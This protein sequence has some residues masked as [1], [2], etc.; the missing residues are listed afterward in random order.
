MLL[1][2]KLKSTQRT[3]WVRRGVKHPESIADHMYRMAALSMIVEPHTGLSKDKCI[4]LAL[5]H[6]MAESITGD[7]TPHDGVSKEEKHRREAVSMRHIEGL[8][9][10]DAGLEIYNLWLEYET[11]SSAEAQFV[12]DVDKFDMILQA[13]EYETEE[14]RPKELE[15]FFQSTEGKFQTSIVR[16]WVDE[17]NDLRRKNSAICVGLEGLLCVVDQSDSTTC[18]SRGVEDDVSR[19]YSTEFA[20]DKLE[21]N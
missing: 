6:D 1:M 8:V 9:G 10:G 11:Q 3:G 18:N 14:G 4:K 2:G 17:L 7:L 19:K 20:K 21:D 12:K 15:E 16:G 5:V 13:Y